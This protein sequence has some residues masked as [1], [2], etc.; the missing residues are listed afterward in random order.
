[1]TTRTLKMYVWF[2]LYLLDRAVLNGLSTRTLY[3]TGGAGGKILTVSQELEGR[4]SMKS[5]EQEGQLCLYLG[6]GQLFP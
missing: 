1:M 3:A 4:A 5:K 2:T 6:L